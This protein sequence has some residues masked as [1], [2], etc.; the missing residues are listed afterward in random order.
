MMPFRLHHLLAAVSAAAS[1]ALSQAA[2]PLLTE[3]TGT[4]GEGKYQLEL[5]FD[6]VTDRPAGV[7]MRELQTTTML[8]WGITDNADLQFGL[9]HLRQHRHDALGHHSRGGL[10]DASLDLK[11]RFYDSEAVSLALKP[12]ITLPSGDA[13]DGFGTGRTTWGSLLVVSYEPGP[14]AFHSHI[15]YRRNEYTVAQRRNLGHVSAA[16][17]WKHSERLRL[18]ADFS[19]DTDPGKT[20]RGSLR[21][22][23]LGLIYSPTETLDLDAGLKHGHGRAA[24]DRALLFGMTYRW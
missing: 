1:C 21:Y 15:G 10:L 24:A 11:W 2:H 6:R 13:R 23:I 9:P 12:G 22:R 3:D 18:V 19:A 20:G 16:L 7:T 14:L 4:Q 17:V 5:M 8:S